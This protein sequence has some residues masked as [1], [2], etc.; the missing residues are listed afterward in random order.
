V[1]GSELAAFLTARGLT[2]PKP[3]NREA[4]ASLLV[5]VHL[6]AHWRH[7]EPS[8]DDVPPDEASR[9]EAAAAAAANVSAVAS[10]NSG[11]GA[12]LPTYPPPSRSSSEGSLNDDEWARVQA[13]LE[14]TPSVKADD[15]KLGAPA[16]EAQTAGKK[17]V[18]RAGPSGGGEGSAFGHL[19]RFLGA[20]GE[21]E[22]GAAAAKGP[23][24]AAGVWQATW[25]LGMRV[26]P[27]PGWRW[28]YEWHVADLDDGA[29][30]GL[31]MRSIG[32]RQTVAATAAG[33]AAA[34]ALAEA[35]TT[36]SAALAAGDAERAWAALSAAPYLMD[37]GERPQAFF[38]RAKEQQA[39][40]PSE[41]QAAAAEKGGSGGG[42]GEEEE[43][44]T[45]PAAQ[46]DAPP[47]ASAD[48]AATSEAAE[49]SDTN[50]G[51]KAA[52]AKPEGLPV[53]KTGRSEE[54]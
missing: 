3:G 30:L 51:E 7:P 22:R 32:A 37:D 6:Y 29:P 31:A 9:S 24:C 25:T 10:P 17:A 2:F 33:A 8:P 48:A 11:R 52:S 28:D 45:L 21:E 5:D 49:V 16:K 38:P 13:L 20:G 18:D 42:G 34:G 1:T 39:P 44:S 54:V 47:G 36:T 50:N 40:C 53:G 14:D 4:F 23:G 46:D 26:D 15:A 27:R 19:L 12:S 43:N 41:L 35:T